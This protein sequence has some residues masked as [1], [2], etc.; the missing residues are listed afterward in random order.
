MIIEYL[1]HSSFLIKGSKSV[2]VDPHSGV[3]YEMP[4]VEAD[5]C[6]L[7]HE[8]F[9][10]NAAN[11]VKKA[12]I[13]HGL[14]TPKCDEILLKTRIVDH[15]KNG[16]SER[17]KN[18]VTYFELDGTSFVHYG[19]IGEAFGG[20]PF[21]KADVAFIPVGGFYTIDAREAVEYVKACG[22]KI[23]IPMHF[24]T[25]R[26]FDVLRGVEEF[27]KYFDNTIRVKEL[28]LSKEE[29]PETLTVCVFDYEKF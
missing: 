4:E 9:D 19:D 11:K 29:L 26:S 24:K 1:G 23:V 17:G 7:S 5:F 3:G 21:F 10:H 12:K 6:I 20:D 8:H 25:P 15:D 27:T 14:N 2:V 22:A 18:A 13:L 16:G 28:E